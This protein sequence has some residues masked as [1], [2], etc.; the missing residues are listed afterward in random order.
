MLPTNTL[1]T[2]LHFCTLSEQPPQT[3]PVPL[4]VY[5]INFAGG[6]PLRATPDRDSTVLGKL[7]RGRCVEVTQTEVKGDRVR[8]R[9]I[10]PGRLQEDH[11][12]WESSA[13][14][15]FTSGWISLLNA[16]TGSGGASPVPLGAYVVVA[17][18]GCAITE[19][20]GLDSKVKGKLIPGSCLEVVAT[21]ME[22]GI[23]RGLVASGGHVTLFVPPWSQRGGAN[24]GGQRS[25]SGRMFAMPVPLGTYQIV[26]DAGVPVTAGA[27]AAS[28]V[29]ATL[30]M[31][32]T[33][34]VVETRVEDGRVRG[35]VGAATLEDGSR[36]TVGGSAGG[37]SSSGAGWI[38]LFE[39]TQRWATI[40]RLQ[41][42]R[43]L[44]RKS[45]QASAGG[46][47]AK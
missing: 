39:P 23:V 5:R 3:E 2:V 25:S 40:V 28:S 36:A 42:G 32:A 41:D 44:R 16:L 4:G 18:S 6:L 45:V 21:R 47:G 17:E 46:S 26:R 37:S 15:K 38:N 22:E 12:E 24:H 11:D 33:A 9:V 30:G 1:T 29:L 20:G 14:H 27:D 10:V 35:R 8:A 13:S 31:N 43:P 34:E 19:G 7:E